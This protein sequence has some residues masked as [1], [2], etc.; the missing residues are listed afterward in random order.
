VLEDSRVLSDI[1]ASAMS[2]MTAENFPVALRILPRRPRQQLRSVYQYARF[3]DDVGDEALGNRVQLLD[4]IEQ[5]VRELPNGRPTLAPVVGLRELVA[6][7]G[8]PLDV[9]VDLIEANRMDQHVLRYET[10]A[11]L[12][13]YCRLSAAP[14]GR[15]VLYVANSVSPQNL[16]LSDAICAGLQV[17]EHCQDVGEDARAG[18]I[19]LPGEEL[20]AARVS[21]SDLGLASTSPALRRVIATQVDRAADLIESGRPLVGHLRGWARLAVAGYVAGGLATVGA[22]RSA[23]HDVLGR[24]ITPTTA[25]T[26]AHAARLLIRGRRLG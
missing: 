8:V 13:A 25:R 12:M 6:Q 7:Q 1:A 20:R 5:D 18:R 22:L 14:V 4:R 9:L 24:A 19:Y 17:L 23:H 21:E 3:V 15:L 11:D 10:F 2:Q 16:A 26:V